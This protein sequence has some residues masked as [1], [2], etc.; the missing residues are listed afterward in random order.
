MFS[1][2]RYLVVVG[3]YG[4]ARRKLCC[5]SFGGFWGRAP[6]TGDGKRSPLVPVQGDDPAGLVHNMM[7]SIFFQTTT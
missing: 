2:S 3:A 4:A 7:H 6:L 5:G 1:S